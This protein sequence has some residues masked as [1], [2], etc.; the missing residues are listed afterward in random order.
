[1]K[2]KPVLPPTYLLLAL[3]MMLALHFLFPLAIAIKTPWLIVGTIPLA[4]GLI[5]NLVADREFKK[6]QTTVKPFEESTTLITTGVYRISRNPMYLGFVLI[7]SGVALFLGSLTPFAVV[8]FFP[9]LME[10]VFIRPEEAM[11]EQQ[12]G[13]TWL[14]YKQQVRRWI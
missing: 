6:H 10:V 12:F 8:L 14:A 5:L 3:V 4:I 2:D 1:M 11:L 7:L 9:G 13:E